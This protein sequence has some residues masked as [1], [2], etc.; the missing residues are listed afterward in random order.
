MLS[1]Q[2]IL[3]STPLGIAPLIK[4]ADSRVQKYD[5]NY[6]ATMAG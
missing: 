5:T 3:H 4:R 6:C 2:A 1:T